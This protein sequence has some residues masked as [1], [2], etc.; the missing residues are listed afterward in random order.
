MDE[1]TVDLKHSV[2]PIELVGTDYTDSLFRFL[3]K[4]F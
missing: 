3:Q 1:K 2:R 4:L